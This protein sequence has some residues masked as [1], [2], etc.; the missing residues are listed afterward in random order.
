MKGYRGIIQTDAYAGYNLA[1]Q[2]GITQAGCWAHV[3]RK[4]FKLTE[5]TKSSVALEAIERINALYQV[6]K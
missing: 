4:L 3:R 1:V 5:S 6:E 2:S